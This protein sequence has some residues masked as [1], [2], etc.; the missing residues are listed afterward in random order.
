MGVL[1]VVDR[2]REGTCAPSREAFAQQGPVDRA[3]SVQT[4]TAE[5]TSAPPVLPET[6]TLPEP[7]IHY[8]SLGEWSL[9][10]PSAQ[11][12]AEELPFWTVAAFNSGL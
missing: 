7:G 9:Y 11:C 5:P 1:R 8:P 3:S 4:L 2:V 6:G 12:T 10:T